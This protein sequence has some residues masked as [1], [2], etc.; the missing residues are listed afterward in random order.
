M[1]DVMREETTNKQLKL[2]LVEAFFNSPV[3]RFG[4]GRKE[5]DKVIPLRD[6]EFVVDGMLEEIINLILD[7]RFVRMYPVS[8]GPS[9]PWHI[10]IP[11]E[12]QAKK[13]H[14][15]QGLRRLAERGG[16]D[17]VEALAIVRDENQFQM[18]AKHGDKECAS[19]W[20]IFAAEVNQK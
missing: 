15:G 16:I 13:N 2:Q 5:S 20:R 18:L 14:G 9:I 17:R 4:K 19:Q 1:G 3:T 10:I 12:T 6:V 7:E 8:G 11:H